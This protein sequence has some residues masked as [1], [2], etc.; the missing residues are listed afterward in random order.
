LGTSSGDTLLFA[1]L[2]DRNNAALVT[3]NC[4]PSSDIWNQFGELYCIA[5]LGVASQHAIPAGS[6]IQSCAA[7]AVSAGV[8]HANCA[9]S[10]DST[11]DN[12]LKLTLC[13]LSDGI[14]NNDG[15]LLCS[16]ATSQ[17]T[18]KTQQAVATLTAPPSGPVQ[19]ALKGAGCSWFLG[20]ANQYLCSTHAAFTQCVG[21][22]AKGQVKSCM[23]PNE[24]H[25]DCRRFLGRD[26]EYLCQSRVAFLQCQ[27]FL[28]KGQLGVTKCLDASPKKTAKRQ[29][30]DTL[31]NRA[32]AARDGNQDRIGLAV[33]M[34]RPAIALLRSTARRAVL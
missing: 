5:K 7:I 10:G 8:L 14:D 9:T 27:N 18:A 34:A 6:Y 2:T 20:R 15:Q 22:V 25:T 32:F 30:N 29:L 31:A 13:D 26:H 3:K 16:P 24:I 1:G 11:R 19:T 17:S 4:E 21:Y 28:T 33:S 12:S 23:A